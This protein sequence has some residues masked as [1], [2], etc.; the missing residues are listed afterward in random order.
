[1]AGEQESV[2]LEVK[3]DGAHCHARR[4]RIAEILLL[5][6]VKRRSALINRSQS[7]EEP[8]DSLLVVLLDKSQTNF[9]GKSLLEDHVFGFFC[10]D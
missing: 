10:V 6:E 1:M 4:L 7:I 9:F 8:S 3:H 5:W 2:V